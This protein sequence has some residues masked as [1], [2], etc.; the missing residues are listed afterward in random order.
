[1]ELRDAF[2]SNE[3]LRI[4]WVMADTQINEKTLRFIDGLGLRERIHFAVDPGS[5]AIDALQIRLE[6]AEAI[7][8]GVPHPTT[9]LLD[10]DGVV[11]FVDTRRDYHMWLDAELVR[12]ALAK[13]P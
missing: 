7:E 3:D 5:R 12:D 2:A 13:I 9:Y 1:M 4:L 11:R 8:A 10:R 6:N